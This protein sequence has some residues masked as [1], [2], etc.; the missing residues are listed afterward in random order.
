MTSSSLHR[1]P[2]ASRRSEVDRL[3][4]ENARLRAELDQ[5]RADAA[6]RGAEVDR[7]QARVREFATALE[8]ARRAAKRQAAPFSRNKPKAHP[9]PGGRKPGAAY[10][11]KAHRLPPAPERVDEVV[12]VPLPG[13]CPRCGGEVVVDAVA[14][15]FQEELVPVGK[16]QMEVAGILELNNASV[17]NMATVES[18]LTPTST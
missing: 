8:E 14:W 4:A 1:C 18:S 12:D 11:T 2:E 16:A 10:G 15:Q 6:A 13:S 17:R 7:L 3:R 9:R 5:A